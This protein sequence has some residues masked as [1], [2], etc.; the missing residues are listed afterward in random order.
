MLEMINV[1]LGEACFPFSVM[2]NDFLI[3][4]KLSWRVPLLELSFHSFFFITE[5]ATDLSRFGVTRVLLVSDPRIHAAGLS[6]RVADVLKS[7]G[8]DIE[9][10]SRP[11]ARPREPQLRPPYVGS[12]P[13]SDLWATKRC[14]SRLWLRE[15]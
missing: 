12:N 8:I 11:Q 1:A 13:I 9:I 3:F 2:D 15:R 10:F 4:Y 7:S 5:I 14:T 6:R